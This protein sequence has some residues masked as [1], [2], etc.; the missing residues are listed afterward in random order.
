V[1][2]SGNPFTSVARAAKS[3]VTDS[4]VQNVANVAAQQY[5]PQKYAQAQQILSQTQRALRAG[6]PRP[7]VMPAR[8]MPTPQM[9][10]L[11]DDM[12]TTGGPVQKGNLL[13]IGGVAV[14]LVML[15]MLRK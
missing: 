10:L 14:A 2:L 3:V 13:L 11:E 9:P 15:L 8:P 5:A 6:Q 1:I 4:R 7:R 12:P